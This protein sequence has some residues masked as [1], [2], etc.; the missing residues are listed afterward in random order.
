[1]PG[2]PMC[3]SIK[4][5][6]TEVYNCDYIKAYLINMITNN[7][8]KI[9]DI[10]ISTD[11]NGSKCVYVC[12]DNWFIHQGQTHT[13]EMSQMSDAFAHGFMYLIPAPCNSDFDN[14]WIIEYVDS[15]IKFDDLV[16]DLSGNEAENVKQMN[17]EIVHVELYDTDLHVDDDD[18]YHTIEYCNKQVDDQD[19][20][21]G[22][23]GDEES[24]DEHEEIDEE[25][26]E[27]DEEDEEDDEED[28]EIDEE[29]EED[30]EDDEEDDDEDEEDEEDE[31]DD[32]ESNKIYVLNRYLGIP[33]YIPIPKDNYEFDKMIQI[34][35]MYWISFTV[36]FM[37]FVVT[38]NTNQTCK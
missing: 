3:I 27:E 4:N 30:E 20:D 1:M 14:D 5:I 12:F 37:L 35:L 23:E 22:E 31:E 15:V 25:I 21:E 6:L 33:L 9:T 32:E 8:V 10:R 18:L 26:D 24:D 38:N 2:E 7:H 29:G 13:H 17:N 28:E 36:I 19:D 16:V 11:K 34:L